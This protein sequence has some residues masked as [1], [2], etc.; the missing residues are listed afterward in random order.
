ML[1]K[2]QVSFLLLSHCL[3]SWPSQPLTNPLHDFPNNHSA[4][5]L[6]VF[7]LDSEWTIIYVSSPNDTDANPGDSP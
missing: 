4:G 7:T 3:T 1:Y 6:F 5:D 2:A